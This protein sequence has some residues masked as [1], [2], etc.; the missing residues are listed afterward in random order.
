MG[1]YINANLSKEGEAFYKRG[2][3]SSPDT[4]IENKDISR[5]AVIKIQTIVNAIQ[6]LDT[7]LQTENATA[8]TISKNLINFFNLNPSENK[9]EQMLYEGLSLAG[10]KSIRKIVKEVFPKTRKN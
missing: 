9:V 8:N 5:S 10:R 4:M 6:T 7:I 3:S 1:D 2:D